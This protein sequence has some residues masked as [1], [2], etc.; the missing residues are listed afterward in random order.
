[1]CAPHFGTA[2]CVLVE[3]APRQAC[4][5]FGVAAQEEIE[6]VRKRQ[7]EREAEKARR[8][9]ELTMMQVWAAFGQR[10]GNVWDGSAAPRVTVGWVAGW[11]AGW[12]V[13]WLISWVAG[14]LDSWLVDQ[15]TGWVA[16]WL[17]S[18]LVDQLAGW[19][20]GWLDSWL[21]A[22][23]AAGW[24]DS[25][26]VDQLAG[27]VVGWLDSWLVDQLDGWVAGWLDSWLVDQLD[28]WL[29]GRHDNVQAPALVRPVV[30]ASKC[31]ACSPSPTPLRPSS[32]SRALAGPWAN[33]D[34]QPTL[35]QVLGPTSAVIP[36]S[37][38]CWRQARQAAR[39][40]FFH[41]SIRATQRVRAAQEA[42]ESEAK[43]EEFYLKA[44][45]G[46]SM[47]RC[48]AAPMC[49]CA[50]AW[51]GCAVFRCALFVCKTCSVWNAGPCGAVRPS[52]M[53]PYVAV[54]APVRPTRPVSYPTIES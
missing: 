29:Q 17:D 46:C 8:E 19:V 49:G 16:G 37:G 39:R 27:W 35:R 9:E 1:M 15:L 40:H 38:R 25:W 10:V 44:K 30:G 14:W 43:E 7:A 5:A 2:P 20:A 53:A 13:G 11:V 31:G 33:L 4:S 52:A 24:L 41:P 36:P 22:G 6:K 50:F 28:G 18:W 23:W 54:I 26:L 3:G 42:M 48:R 12:T 21:L 47:L 45:A 32:P 51:S 34:N